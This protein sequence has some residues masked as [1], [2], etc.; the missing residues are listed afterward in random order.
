MR[1]FV[2]KP[3]LHCIYQKSV[4]PGPGR[5]LGPQVQSIAFS[6]RVS[7]TSHISATTT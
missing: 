2:K 7:G 5:A 3:R 1:E 4:V 6:M